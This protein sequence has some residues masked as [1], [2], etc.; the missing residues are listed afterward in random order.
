MENDSQ[1]QARQRRELKRQCKAALREAMRFLEFKKREAIIADK[2]ARVQERRARR[3]EQKILHLQNEARQARALAEAAA[4]D[5][6]IAREQVVRKLAAVREAD[7]VLKAR[8]SAK[9][10]RNIVPS[11][12]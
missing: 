2:K 10:R 11:I 5:M 8:K 7:Q 1:N 12:S 9:A 6:E 3:W 4:Q